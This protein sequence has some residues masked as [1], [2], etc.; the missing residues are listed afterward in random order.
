MMS[1]FTNGRRAVENNHAVNSYRLKGCVGGCVLDFN[2]QGRAVPSVT[3]WS[4]FGSVRFCTA[5][6]QF[7]LKR[8]TMALREMGHTG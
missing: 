4:W 5:M 8:N 2:S 7:V 6:M 3:G 1:L